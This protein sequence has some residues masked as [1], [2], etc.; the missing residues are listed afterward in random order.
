[1]WAKFDAKSVMVWAICD[2]SLGNYFSNDGRQLKERL[3]EYYEFPLKRTK[4]EFT[5]SKGRRP[6]VWSKG[7]QLKHILNKTCNIL[8]DKG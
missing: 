2:K 7:S 8:S 1:M 6:G 5:V 4:L 3:E